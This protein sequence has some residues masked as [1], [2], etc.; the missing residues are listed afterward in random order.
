MVTN[1]LSD[2]EIQAVERANDSGLPP[3]VFVHGLWLLANSWAPWAEYFQKSGYAPVLPGWPDDPQTVTEANADPAVF[4]RKSI[5]QVTNHYET[6]IRSLRMKPAV[7]GHSFG[8]LVTE[9]LA[10]R[11]LSAV[12]VAIAPAPSRGVLPLPISALV[13]SWP[14]L[15][16]PGN[17]HRAVPLTYEQFHFAFGNALSEDEARSLFERYAVP[18]SGTPVFEAAT[19]N[20]NPWTEDRV[21]R[22][23]DRG[24]LLLVVG[25]RDHT[26]PPEIVKA[27]YHHEQHNP[28]VTEYVEVPG[29]G[30]SLTID[31][32]WQP[33][34]EIVLQF[35]Q[36]FLPAAPMAR[37][38]S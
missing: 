5:R 15:R 3:V 9:M 34:A 31:H 30:H 21:E 17:L 22:N 25:D 24:P 38:Q 37:N 28:G 29:R 26:V 10:G 4:A 14:V 33:V 6:V 12:S 32:G 19:A 1:T 11:A 2:D 13:S 23:A 27:S 18:G 8:A 7:I 16:K 35:V 36:R 20:I